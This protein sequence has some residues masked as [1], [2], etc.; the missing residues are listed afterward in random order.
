MFRIKMVQM[1]MAL[2]RPVDQRIPDDYVTTKG[3]LKAIHLLSIFGQVEDSALTCSE[4][5]DRFFFFPDKYI[6][7][8]LFSRGHIC[9]NLVA[10]HDVLVGG[11]RQR[12]SSLFVRELGIE[13]S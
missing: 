9:Y 2:A 1:E 7:W 8:L 10:K 13:I 11:A 12:E 5:I 6:L 4:H 3:L